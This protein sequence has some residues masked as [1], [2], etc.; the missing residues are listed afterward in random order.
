MWAI[1]ASSITCSDHP[2]PDARSPTRPL[3]RRQAN[4]A[5]RLASPAGQPGNLATTA[6]QN[7]C[8]T[9]P[10]F[11][12]RDPDRCDM[13]LL[14][15]RRATPTS[16]A[17]P[18]S[19]LRAIPL[20]RARVRLARCGP[21]WARRRRTG[22]ERRGVRRSCLRG[23]AGPFS[24]RSPPLIAP[25]KGYRSKRT[26]KGSVVAS[27]GCLFASSA[28]ANRCLMAHWLA[29]SPNPDTCSSSTST[30]RGSP[31]VPTS[32]RILTST[33]AIFSSLRG[34]SE[35]QSHALLRKRGG[36]VSGGACGAWDGG[37]LGGGVARQAWTQSI[38]AQ[39]I[40]AFT[41]L[42]HPARPRAS[43]QA[44]QGGAASVRVDGILCSPAS[45]RT[46]L[47]RHRQPRPVRARA[48]DE[49]VAGGNSS[50]QP[51]APRRAGG[52]GGAAGVARAGR[53]Q[54]ARAD[55]RAGARGSRRGAAG[56]TRSLAVAVPWWLGRAATTRGPWW[57]DW[58]AT[59]RPVP[60]CSIWLSEQPITQARC[61]GD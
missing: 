42:V 37:A 8:T 53:C 44:R 34:Q 2:S 7:A 9:H 16:G 26:G 11:P 22:V 39:A 58:T 29:A 15:V 32:T 4:R 23:L 19:D 24:R 51:P 54:T 12:L 6:T 49:V 38:R 41:G 52:R 14:P 40:R 31:S 18:A 46:E 36:V 21:A 45:G 60:Y 3:S 61:A 57:L 59:R 20:A 47:P 5:M 33:R 1:T 48:G 27:T 43:S 35:L 13:G 28:G 25:W 55:G 30:R 50:C 17:G 10:R 56:A